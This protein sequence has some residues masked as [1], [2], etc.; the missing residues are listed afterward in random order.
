MVVQT[1]LRTTFIFSLPF[2]F[3]NLLILIFLPFLVSF[4]VMNWPPSVQFSYQNAHI[5][6]NLSDKNC[7]KLTTCCNLFLYQCPYLVASEASLRTLSSFLLG[8]MVRN[9][10]CKRIWTTECGMWREPVINVSSTRYVQSSLNKVD[11]GDR[12]YSF[13]VTYL[14]IS[15]RLPSKAHY[16]TDQ[17]NPA[18]AITIANR[19]LHC[20]P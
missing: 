11:D 2:Q 5:T 6:F 8:R 18:W 13:L 4:R 16:W 15:V 9:V 1:C 7:K 10:R 19:S 17:A 20:D 14:L 12:N 3:S